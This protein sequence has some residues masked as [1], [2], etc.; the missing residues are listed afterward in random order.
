[1]TVFE[2]T[3]IRKKISC[4]CGHILH[5][6]IWICRALFLVIGLAW[7]KKKLGM[8]D[9]S[10]AVQVPE[11]VYEIS[12]YLLIF[13]LPTSKSSFILDCPW[14]EFVLTQLT[15]Y[16]DSGWCTKTVL[17]IL[18]KVLPS[19]RSFYKND[20]MLSILHCNFYVT[21]KIMVSLLKEDLEYFLCL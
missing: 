13:Q 16:L 19:Q 5:R 4:Q 10:E 9:V 1:M 15:R 14:R 3:I 17:Y 8:N 20:I 7:W 12:T 11:G 2:I 21:N 18:G 6:L